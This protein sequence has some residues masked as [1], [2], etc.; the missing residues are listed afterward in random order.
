MRT[1]S[2]SLNQSRAAACN[3]NMRPTTHQPTHSAQEGRRQRVWRSQCTRLGVGAQPLASVTLKHLFAVTISRKGPLAAALFGWSSAGIV[4][5]RYQ[6]VPVMHPPAGMPRMSMRLSAPGLRALFLLSSAPWPDTG[7]PSSRPFVTLALQPASDTG[8]DLD[9]DVALSGSR[10]E[11]SLAVQLHAEFVSRYPPAHLAHPLLTS[12]HFHVQHT[13][14]ACAIA[15]FEASFVIF[16]L[17]LRPL[18]ILGSSASLRLCCTPLQSWPQRLTPDMYSRQ[19][20]HA[21]RLAARRGLVITAGPRGQ[22]PCADVTFCFCGRRGA[23]MSSALI[24]EGS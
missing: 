3:A 24:G 9:V 22:W 8:M 17:A 7:Q 12:P 6:R 10:F 23:A 21:S 1:A 13:C 14:A 19:A 4:H 15:G 2:A 5:G 20:L 18:P 11:P 16:L